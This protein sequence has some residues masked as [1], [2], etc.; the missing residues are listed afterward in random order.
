MHAFGLRLLFPPQA[1]GGEER[2][3]SSIS[4]QR[5]ILLERRFAN[6]LLKSVLAAAFDWILKFWSNV[7]TSAGLDIWLR[8]ASS[9]AFVWLIVEGGKRPR[10]YDKHAN[11]NI[12]Q[13]GGM[14]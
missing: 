10:L 3:A 13:N 11:V 14:H 6:P 1:R 2:L 9:T 4:A 5:G 8:I 7:R 12:S